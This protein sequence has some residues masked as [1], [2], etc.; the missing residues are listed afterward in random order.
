[1][2]FTSYLLLSLCH[3]L[4]I[5]LSVGIA[6][7]AM[8]QYSLIFQYLNYC[9]ML[10][11]AI[12]GVYH[13]RDK[14]L[15]RVV[16]HAVMRMKRELQDKEFRSNISQMAGDAVVNAMTS[17]IEI[18]NPET[19]EK[20][21]I[22]VPGLLANSVYMH[23]L[24]DKG[25]LSRDMKKLEGELTELAIP[26]QWRP[27]AAQILPIVKRHPKVMSAFGT[28]AAM[29]QKGGAPGGLGQSTYAPSMY[30]GV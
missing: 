12:I 20:R 24:G 10:I 4:P 25:V 29:M 19:G 7:Q 8:P 6:S 30:G 22:S 18:Q 21:M 14:I 5:E 26:E 9:Y 23:F 28:M 16:S 27:L 3:L 17:E 2:K 15:E 13:W 11:V 1:M